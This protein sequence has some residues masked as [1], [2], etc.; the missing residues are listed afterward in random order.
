M[1][2]FFSLLIAVK[3]ENIYLNNYFKVVKLVFI[4]SFQLISSSKQSSDHN[5]DTYIIYNIQI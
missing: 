5:T 1:I 3:H 4:P 2:T